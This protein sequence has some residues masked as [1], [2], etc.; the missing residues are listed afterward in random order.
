VQQ[1]QIKG[2]V[3]VN[4]LAQEQQTNPSAAACEQDQPLRPTSRWHPSPGYFGTANPD[5]SGRD[6]EVA[7]ERKLPRGAHRVAGQHGDGRRSQAG[8]RRDGVRPRGA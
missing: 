1:A 7:G 8:H 4:D 3:G 2:F 6:A 5:A